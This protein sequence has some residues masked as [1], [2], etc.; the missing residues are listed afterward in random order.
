[1]LMIQNKDGILWLELNKDGRDMK[2]FMIEFKLSQSKTDCYNLK[3]VLCNFHGNHKENTYRLNNK[4]K[5]IKICHTN[6]KNKN[7]SKEMMQ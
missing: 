1:M 6:N 2:I 3:E 5:S 4:K 7:N